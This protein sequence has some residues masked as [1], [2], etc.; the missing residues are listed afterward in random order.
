MPSPADTRLSF[1]QALQSPCLS[2]K[3]SPCCTHLLLGTI[4][5]TTLAEVDHALYLLNFEG[6]YLSPTSGAEAARLYLHQPCGHLDQGSGLCTIHSTPELPPIC[7][8]YKAHSCDYR[9]I[10]ADEGSER[11][12]VADHRRMSWLAEHMV[13]DDRRRVVA[14]PPAEQ[15]LEAWSRLPLDHRPAPGREPGWQ[16]VSLRGRQGSQPEGLYGIEDPEV[17][18]PCTGCSAW[19]CRTLEFDR[20]LPATISQ[21]EFMRYSLGFP[22]VEL[23]ISDSTWSLVVHTTCRHLSDG[24]CSIY[25]LPERPLGCAAYDELGCQY[26]IRYGTPDRSRARISGREFPALAE[27]VVF[28]QRGRILAVPSVD[29][30]REHLSQAAAAP[31]A[32]AKAN[33]HTTDEESDPLPW[34]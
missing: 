10:F 18:A 6:L 28:D 17:S 16:P 3:S 12:P 33:V 19:C 11:A 21:L 29:V 1:R 5:L 24:R 25:G 15:V 9:W 27:L 2:C 34:R 32:G 4:P 7:A 13:F 30:I 26:R 14:T 22:S 23:S 20:G 31:A 8:S